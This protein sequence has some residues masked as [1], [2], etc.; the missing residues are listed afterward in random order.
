MD[1]KEDKKTR[2]LYYQPVSGM[3]A[4]EQQQINKQDDND[5]IEEEQEQQIEEQPQ[6]ARSPTGGGI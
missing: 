5:E 4:Q 1:V 3:T 2:K 6:P